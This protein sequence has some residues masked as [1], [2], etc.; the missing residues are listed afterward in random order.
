MK[1]TIAACVAGLTVG[2]L[3]L[4]PSAS[5]ATGTQRFSLLVHFTDE[6]VSSCMVVAIGPISGVGS[7]LLAG[8][9]G[10]V[11]RATLPAGD[12]DLIANRVRRRVTSTRNPACSGSRRPTPSPSPGCPE[13]TPRRPGRPPGTRVARSST[14]TRRAAAIVRTA[15]AWSWPAP[16]GRRRSDLAATPAARVNDKRNIEIS[17]SRRPLVVGLGS[18]KARQRLSTSLRR[19]G[20]SG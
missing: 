16:P 14:P 3:G 4:A 6:E 2:V 17:P 13:R 12:V 9:D 7:C 11:V 1:K 20:G 19:L 18:C 15:T 8:E 10:E 5:A